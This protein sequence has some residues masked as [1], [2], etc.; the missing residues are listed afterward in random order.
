MEDGGLMRRVVL[1]DLGLP[2]TNAAVLGAERLKETCLPALLKAT[3]GAGVKVENTEAQRKSLKTWMACF[4]YIAKRVRVGGEKGTELKQAADVERSFTITQ[5]LRA[6]DVSFVEFAR[7]LRHIMARAKPTILAECASAGDENESENKGNPVEI[8]LEM[9][10]LSM[11]F[12][13]LSALFSKYKD[14]FQV[15]FTSESEAA[16]PTNLSPAKATPGNQQDAGGPASDW[17]SD[18]WFKF[19]WLTFVTCKEALLPKF[20]DLVSCA[21]LLVCVMNFLLAHVPPSRMRKT[22]ND[23]IA[24]PVRTATGATYTLGCVAFLLHAPLADAQKMMPRVDDLLHELL[25]KDPVIER[26]EAMVDAVIMTGC[27]N[28]KGLL[29]VGAEDRQLEILD[30]AY[31]QAYRLGGELDA[32][33]F[34]SSAK[35]KAMGNSSKMTPRLNKR[36]PLNTAGG[37]GIIKQKENRNWSYPSPFRRQVAGVP[38]SPALFP[39]QVTPSTPISEALAA[40]QWLRKAVEKHMERDSH[41]DSDL[42][43]IFVM[44][45]EKSCKDI[46]E[47]IEKY[48]QDLAD[49]ILPAVGSPLGK[50]KASST[51]SFTSEAEKRKKEGIALYFHILEAMLVAEEKR[52]GGDV[53]LSLLLNKDLHVSLVAFAFEVLSD[54]YK[55][56]ALSFPTVLNRLSISAFDLCKVIEPLVRAEVNLNLPKEVKKHLYAIEETGLESLSWKKGSPFYKEMVAC[57]NNNKEME[58]GGSSAFQKVQPL[59]KAFGRP[60]AMDASNSQ[61][62]PSSSSEKT[63]GEFLRK[64]QKLATFRMIDL[65]NRLERGLKFRKEGGGLV[66]AGL[67]LGQAVSIIEFVI[68]EQTRLMY[69]RHI[70]QIV[71]CTLYGVAKVNSCIVTFREI[72]HHY[73]KQTQCKQE[74]YRAVVLKQTYPDLQ[75]EETGDIIQFY[76]RCFVPVVQNEL[77]N[78]VSN[79]KREREPET[80]SRKQGATSP[81]RGEDKKAALRQRTTN[82]KG[83]AGGES[84]RTPARIHHNTKMS[85]PLRV[86][87]LPD[88]ARQ[89]YL[90]ASPSSHSLFTFI[91]TPLDQNETPTKRWEEINNKLN[92]SSMPGSPP[93]A[94][95]A[96]TAADAAESSQQLETQVSGTQNKRVRV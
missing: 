48:V 44:C 5:L 10:E 6:C 17:E 52:A 20:P 25:S 82:G 30:K 71:L 57:R 75:I 60:G 39:N 29:A 66:D 14:K 53:L 47:K 64:V 63:L 88:S 34:A 90:L 35:N 65:C 93:K 51:N 42:S 72:V 85:S 12:C 45:S 15:L 24:Y 41:S 58:E 7:E 70:D 69:N 18:P 22:L 3:E 19:G 33:D 27:G 86:R 83:Q 59:P 11:D 40:S 31:D 61:G 46:K 80:P 21:S 49:K 8:A 87:T 26:Y 73:S 81:P 38:Q 43:R 95:A 13:H 89:E 1:E 78:I 23:A 32:R 37:R 54:C 9:S 77:L 94:A 28:Y 16:A 68:Y 84:P 79:S 67:I 4:L 62:K 74:V 92:S 50:R 36:G 96:A 91:G 56:T 76:N 2:E 55:M